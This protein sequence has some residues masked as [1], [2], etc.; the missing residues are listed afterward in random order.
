MSSGA[1][2]SRST[3]SAIAI[4]LYITAVAITKRHFDALGQGRSPGAE[5]LE[6]TARALSASASNA[7]FSLAVP[8]AGSGREDAA[9]AVQSAMLAVLAARRTTRDPR[10]LRRIALAALFVDAGKASLAGREQ[11]D[12]GVFRQLP[13]ALDRRVPIENVML[14]VA[15]HA[16]PVLESAAIVAFETAWLERPQLG[17]LYAGRIE[18]RRATRLLFAARQ[19]LELCA[20]RAHDD[21]LAP[22]EALKLLAGRREHD[23]TALRLLTDAVGLIPVGSVVELSSGQWAAVAPPA[24]PQAERP[25]VRILTDAQGRAADRPALLDLGGS[26]DS[27]EVLPRILRVLG[28]REAR[29]NVMRAFMLPPG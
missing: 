13:D 7:S 21:P 2:T 14:G 1:P 20:P 19:F 10:A 6:Q 3:E 5:F 23:G 27:K 25:K 28:P 8:L 9:R 15:P 17:P 12:L 4:E 11:V 18:P 29:F 26:P 22:F 24:A 16:S